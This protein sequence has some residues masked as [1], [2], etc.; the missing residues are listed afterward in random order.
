MRSI[1]ILSVLAALLA[2]ALPSSAQSLQPASVLGREHVI[3]KSYETSQRGDGSSGSSSG[4]DALVE[5]VVG[6]RDG[7]LEVEYDLPN[8]ATAADRARNWQFPVRV[9]KPSAGPMQLLNPGELEARVD[10]WL[11]MAGLARAS[12]GRSI[13][14]WNVFRIECDPQSAIKIVEAFDLRIA[15]LRDG[16]P[17][18]EPRARR[19]GTLRRKAAGPRGATYAVVLE[20]DP[21][22]VRRTR[23]ELD[24]AVGEIMGKP[25]TLEAA[26]RQRGKESVSGTMS[27]TLDTDAAGTVERRT[28]VTKLKTRGPDGRSEETN[29]ETV[30]RRTA[31]APSALR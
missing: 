8:G 17:Y 24:V 31:T 10:A 28:T 20:I 15:N 16:A 1:G 26:L 7:G 4:R 29:T 3:I 6:V 21:D 13:F 11:A 12:C 2:P 25:V 22:A 23:A 19:P 18:R 14:T 9:F 5:R 30:E 27:I